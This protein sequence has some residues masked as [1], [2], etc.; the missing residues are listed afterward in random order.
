MPTDRPHVNELVEAVREFLER[1]VQ[2]A[3]EGSLNFHTRVAVNVLRIVE[4]ELDT[5]E[6]LRA[7][8]RARLVALL[9]REGD[10]DKLSQSLIDGI[11]AGELDMNTPGLTDH[12]RA[13][14]LDKLAI[15]NPRYK[16]YQRAVAEQNDS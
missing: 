13:T 1:E 5:G 2:P 6:R 3:L 14:V 8:E 7:D 15:D 12:L 10:L 4:R 9:G 16:S 11:R